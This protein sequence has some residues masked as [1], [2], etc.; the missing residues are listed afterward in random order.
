MFDLVYNRITPFNCAIFATIFLVFVFSRIYVADGTLRFDCKR[1]HYDFSFFKLFVSG[2]PMFLL[3][4]LQYDVGADYIAYVRY[5]LEEIPFTKEPIYGFLNSWLADA[6]FH[7]QSIFVVTSFLCIYILLW[8]ILRYSKMPLLSIFLFYV[9]GFYYIPFNEIRWGV[10]IAITTYSVRYIEERRL[11]N[12]LFGMLLA[13]GFH[14]SS[15]VFIPMYWVYN[16]RWSFKWLWIVTLGLV[17]VRPLIGLAVR[18]LIEYTRYAHYLG[19]IYDAGKQA[20]LGILV[21]IAILLATGLLVREK[22]KLCIFY[23][24]CVFVKLWIFIISEYVPLVGRFGDYFM[25]MLIFLIPLTGESIENVKLRLSYILSVII[26]FCGFF[27]YRT[28]MTVE[29]ID[30]VSIWRDYVTIFDTVMKW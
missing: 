15:V 5:F 20:M 25:I 26:C 22:N 19:G 10:A 18:I 9:A 23:S 13:I 2:L 14:Y 8:S 29:K 11:P 7:Y 16:I 12:F 17:L 30:S 4:A 3:P 6:G 21:P 24:V 28:M 1:P 27:F